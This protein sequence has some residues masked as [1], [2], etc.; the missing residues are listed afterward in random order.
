MGGALITF[1]KIPIGTGGGLSCRACDA[2]GP[3]VEQFDSVEQLLAGVRETTLE[4]DCGPGPNIA[5]VGP[6]PFHHP[7]LVTL[8]RGA[9]EAGVE[10]M[11]LSTDATALAR[12]E[13]AAGAVSGG[14]RHVEV[15]LLGGSAEIHDALSG[16]AGSFDAAISGMRALRD[17]GIAQSV[18][19]LVCGRVRVCS[20]NVKDLPEAVLAFASVNASSVTLHF[21]GTVPAAV[22]R[23]WVSAAIETGVINSVWVALEGVTAQ[24]MGVHPLHDLN[25]VRIAERAAG[26]AS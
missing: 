6:E 2:S 7:E 4:W 21:D 9:I 16:R 13:N 23:P 5:Y 12:G 11:C 19:V 14:V 17:A 1:V 15:Q 25:T 10:R 22:A 3:S 20:H 8:V 18:P 26:A 24:Q